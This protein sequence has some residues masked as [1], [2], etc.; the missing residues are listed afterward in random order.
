MTGIL[1]C[2]LSVWV[3]FVIFSSLLGGGQPIRNAEDNAHV[4]MSKTMNAFADQAD[5]IKVQTDCAKSAVTKL[6]ASKENSRLQNMASC[7]A[8]L[9]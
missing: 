5:N 3:I 7:P 9:K 8:W 2:I 1:K 4:I 6:A